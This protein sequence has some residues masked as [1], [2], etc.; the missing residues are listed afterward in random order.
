M[1]VTQDAPL[2]AAL[3]SRAEEKFKE[4]TQKLL[5]ALPKATRTLLKQLGAPPLQAGNSVES[6]SQELG[7]FLETIIQRIA[8]QKKDQTRSAKA[9]RLVQKIFKASYPFANTL[10][11]LAGQAKDYVR[12]TEC[13]Q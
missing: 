1:S 3:D 6:T 12:A 9:K 4:A 5:K 7:K 10:I 2:P 8:D 13:S 11:N